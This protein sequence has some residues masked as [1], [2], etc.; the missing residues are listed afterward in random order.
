MV[1][2]QHAAAFAF[3]LLLTVAMTWPLARNIDR[4]V[5]WSGDP[6]IN[7]WILDWDWCATFHQPLH[8]FDANA[9]YPARDSLAFSENLYG[10]AMLLFPFRA[11]GVPPVAAHNLGIL[12]GFALSGFGAY[13]LGRLITGSAMAGV[14]AGVFYAFLPFR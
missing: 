6:Y 4:G 14:A 1:A 5:A 9:F 10:I 3:F 12:T 11:A 2:R 8:L 7:T 13:L